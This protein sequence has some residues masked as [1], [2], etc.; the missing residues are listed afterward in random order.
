[1]QSDSFGSGNKGCVLWSVMVRCRLWHGCVCV[2]V[3][4]EIRYRDGVAKIIIVEFLGLLGYL[5]GDFILTHPYS[6]TLNTL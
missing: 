4:G 3:C 5:F 2:C 1:M 6:Y